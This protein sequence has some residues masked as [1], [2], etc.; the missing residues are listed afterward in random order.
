MAQ[1]TPQIA[2]KGYSPNPHPLGTRIMGNKIIL[3]DEAM[4][5]R[6]QWAFWR[7]ECRPNGETFSNTNLGPSTVPAHRHQNIYVPVTN[8]CLSV[9]LLTHICSVLFHYYYQYFL[10]SLIIECTCMCMVSLP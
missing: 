4:R 8:V 2:S 10:L 9:S 1:K 5:H 7:K 3:K 6:E